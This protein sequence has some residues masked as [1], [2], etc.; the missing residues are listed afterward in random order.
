M[1]VASMSHGGIEG[2]AM[3]GSGRVWHRHEWFKA[4]RAKMG[5]VCRPTAPAIH[6]ISETAI[7]T[8]I[9]AGKI[10]AEPVFSVTGGLRG[11]VPR[12]GFTPDL[13][14][15]VPM[16]NEQPGCRRSSRQC[17]ATGRLTYFVIITSSLTSYHYDLKSPDTR[18]RPCARPARHGQYVM[19]FKNY[20]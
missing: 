3:R 6:A 9:F 19:I 13:H 10:C 15:T 1:A 4:N 20:I 12:V 18:D 17:S 8:G 5:Q 11:L 2:G 7:Q 14:G 16:S